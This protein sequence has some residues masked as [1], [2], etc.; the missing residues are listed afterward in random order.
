MNLVKSIA[1]AAA[2]SAFTAGAAFAGDVFTARLEGA[3]PEAR[4]VARSTV[5]TCA[6]TV[7]RARPEHS[8]SVSACR[9]FVREAG[10]VTAYGTED[11]QLTAEQLAACNASSRQVRNAAPATEQA[12]N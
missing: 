4:I 6:D 5:W 12:A 2:F 3:A 9:A 11:E 7:C 10:P 8:A 1:V